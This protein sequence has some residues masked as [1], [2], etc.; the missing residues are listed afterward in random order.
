MTIDDFV[1]TWSGIF[2]TDRNLSY[3]P[4]GFDVSYQSGSISKVDTDTISIIIDS[5]PL[6]FNVENNRATLANAPVTTASAVY[7]AIS[8][9]TDGL[10]LSWYLVGAELSDPTDVSV[11]IGLMTKQ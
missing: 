9:V 10:G 7:H 11:D 2:Y 6:L 8:I 5:E 1:G 3:T 4:E